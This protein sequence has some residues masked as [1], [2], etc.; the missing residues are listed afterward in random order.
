M[1]DSVEIPTTTMGFS[2]QGYS[3]NLL[4]A[5]NVPQRRNNRHNHKLSVIIA[6]HSSSW[7]ESSVRRAFHATTRCDG[8]TMFSDQPVPILLC[9]RPPQGGGI[10]KWWPVSVCLFV[11]QSVCRVPR[12]SHLTRERKGLG[13]PQLVRWNP[14]TYMGNLLRG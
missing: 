3:V 10:M 12:P 9:P 11:C 4:P 14:I 13:S 8:E 6:I 1:I 2:L 7:P 5:D